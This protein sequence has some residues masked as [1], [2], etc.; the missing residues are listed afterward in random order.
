MKLR[1]ALAFLFG[2]MI[3]LSSLSA[4]AGEVSGCGS[5]RERDHKSTRKSNQPQHEK[6]L[7][8]YGMCRDEWGG[9]GGPMFNYL[10]LDLS[11]LHPMAKDRGISNPGGD[12]LLYGGLGGWIYK[13]LRFGGFG[14]GGDSNSRGTVMGQ[15]REA[16]FAIGGGGVFGELNHTLTRNLGVQAGAMLGAGG[17]R[18]KAEGEDLGPLGKWSANQ[19]LFL[20]YPYAGIWL[21]PVDWM[22]VQ[23]NAGWLFSGIDTSG[24]DFMNPYTGV[25]MTHGNI[26]G[27]FMGSVQFLFGRNPNHK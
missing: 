1:G 2:A 23:L 19:A 16:D 14:F 26:D 27:G 24:P 7:P 11:V 12:M 3:L 9:F 8:K 4:Q 5:D 20:A 6:K 25:H 13:D 22:W 10:N 17:V 21:S 18:L 15:K